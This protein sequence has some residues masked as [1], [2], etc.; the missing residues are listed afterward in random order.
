MDDEPVPVV[1]VLL[2]RVRVHAQ[3]LG[4]VD[5]ERERGEL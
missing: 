1:I 3:V 2:V 4:L 5:T